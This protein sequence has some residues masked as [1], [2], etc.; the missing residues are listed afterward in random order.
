MLHR[1]QTCSILTRWRLMGTLGL[2]KMMLAVGTGTAAS[3]DGIAEAL[4]VLAVDHCHSRWQRLMLVMGLPVVEQAAK[5]LEGN[6]IARVNEAYVGG[7]E[8]LDQRCWLLGLGSGAARWARCR[9]TKVL[10][11]HQLVLLDESCQVDHGRWWEGELLGRLRCSWDRSTDNIRVGALG[12]RGLRGLR[13]NRA[14][15]EVRQGWLVRHRQSRGGLSRSRRRGG[16]RWLVNPMVG[17]RRETRHWRV[18][19]GKRRRRGNNRGIRAALRWLAGLR[20]PYL[21]GRARGTEGGGR[22]GGGR[23]RA[24]M[25]TGALGGWVR[26]GLGGL[27]QSGHPTRHV[28]IQRLVMRR[29]TLE[30]E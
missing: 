19:T 16:G 10:R 18:E 3:E 29:E 1:G 20:S 22:R 23:H 7:R 17:R 2:G 5:A 11:L 15:E 6:T 4:A 21:L 28:K 27:G 30:N 12:L 13:E 26:L 9:A 25:G 8:G 24:C 14:L